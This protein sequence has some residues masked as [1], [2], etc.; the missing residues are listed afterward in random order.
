MGFADR[1]RPALPAELV[2]RVLLVWALVAAIFVVTRWPAIAALQPAGHDDLL[3][4]VQLRD[5]F[6]GQ[7]WFD[8]AQHRLAPP[9]GAELGWSR[10][11]DLPAF[12][13][14]TALRPLLGDGA[15]RAALT[16]S[17]LLALAAAM[18]LTGRI[19]WLI[20]DAEL[21]FYAAF[22]VALG[23]PL[24]AAMQPLELGQGAWQ[25]VALLAAVNG[26][27]ARRAR[28]GGWMIGLSLAAL[29]TLGLDTAPLALLVLFVLAR[30]WVAR[31]SER[32][33]LVHAALALFVGATALFYATRGTALPDPALALGPAWLA[34]LAVLAAGCGLIGAV[35][36]LPRVP[37]VLAL[38][39][40]AAASAMTI[41][42]VDPLALA[43]PGTAILAGQPAFA[44]FSQAPAALAQ[45]L[46]PPLLALVATAALCGRAQAWLRGF[47][48]DWAVLL[49]GAIA[50]AV[51]GSGQAALAWALAIVP[52]AW[53]VRQWHRGAQKVR[54]PSRRIA[55]F[56]V[57][58]AAV[59]P[60][61]PML[62]LGA[63]LPSPARAAAP[64]AAA[65]DASGLRL[66]TG[67]DLVF[68]PAALGT[69]LL[70]H[71]RHAVVV[72]DHWRLHDAARRA[73]RLLDSAP[74]AA[75]PGL[76]SSGAAYLA[77]C[78]NM[79]AA[80]G[81]LAARLLRGDPLPGLVPVAT[82][83]GVRAWRIR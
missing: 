80:P 2:A 81:G 49:A 24:A 83:R 75:L 60:G 41:S 19:V 35:P 17:P 36:N 69:D 23:T 6:A 76:R 57:V 73:A 47:W 82:G 21:V 53:Q 14:D 5:L 38:A 55:A 58:A 3:H 18:L 10:L 37:L 54:D 50:V 45:A 68:A 7:G 71:T 59:I 30:R 31:S 29:L 32:G 61:M 27:T 8:L 1:R 26:L 42:L 12:V 33:W 72:V 20:F 46:L 40:A 44:L 43:A 28:A 79:A 25:V 52:L 9:Q 39:L 16:L 51:V 67:R 65:C 4:L 70:V 11:G 63:A 74:G 64:P 34:G 62:A 22:L 66:G 77:L 13:I 48:S 15:A 78:P 56:A